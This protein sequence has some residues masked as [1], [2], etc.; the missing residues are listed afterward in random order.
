MDAENLNLMIEMEERK[1]SWVNLNSRE[2]RE[3]ETENKDQNQKPL[4]D[5]YGR[6]FDYLRI[7]LTDKCN[8][9]CFYC[10]PYR[11]PLF[12]RDEILTF[13]EITFLSRF[14]VERFGIK[15]I[16]ITGGEPFMRRGIEKLFEKLSEIDVE[17]CITT[18]GTL[19][20]EYSEIL[21]HYNVK[22]NV[23]LDTL[24][25]SKFQKIIGLSFPLKKILKGI[26][27][28]LSLGL[29]LKINTV[30]LRNINTDEIH[31]LIDFARD[32]G[33]EIRF[34]EFMP[35]S[36][37]WKEY[38]VPEKEIKKIMHEK[39]E[40]R[41]IKREKIAKL[42]ELSNGV[43]VGFISTVSEPFCNMCSRIRI[44]SNGKIVLCMFDR[45][46]Y[47]IKKFLRPEIKEEEL[48]KFIRSIVLRKPKGFI[49]LKENKNEK[50][51]IPMIKLG[52]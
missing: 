47:D 43:R 16:R 38:F 4:E 45:F 12:P 51:Y 8:F 31:K 34:I 21:K 15:K 52:G 1:T 40:M 13:E 48:E 2:K 44:T 22:V 24:D 7:S 23:S 36:P 10:R 17:K 41:E 20:S 28:S 35:F 27:K 19:L 14:F 26:D 39:Y 30:V 11:I 9:Q 29:S 37:L 42:Y 32:R 3:T 25:E 49:E 46:S 6:K 50:A 5:G 33:V 18:N